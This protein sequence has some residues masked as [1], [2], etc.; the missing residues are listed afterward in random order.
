MEIDAENSQSTIHL[1]ILGILL[2]L[3]VVV[4]H[5]AT[6]K[7]LSSYV[8]LPGISTAISMFISGISG[9]YLSERAEQKKSHDE[10]NKAM[11]I[12]DKADAEDD[13]LKKQEEELKK[14]ML[15]P[16]SLKKHHI[17]SKKKKKNI[18]S[19]RSKA[20][21]FAGIIVALV[22][23]GAPFLGGLIPLLP[24]VFVMEAN[25]ITFVISFIIIFICI[26]LLGVFLGLVSKESIIKKII[27]MLAAFLLTIVMVVIFL[28]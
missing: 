9:S 4:L 19:I 16:V 13:D 24:F 18:K 17:K 2:G 10:L 11:A 25:V 6:P 7:I 8:L 12:V 23:G 5:P 27:Q 3:F 15:K 28:G 14:A 26:I 20:E 21:R 22:N 1:T